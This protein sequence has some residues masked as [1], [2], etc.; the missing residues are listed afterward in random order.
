[1]HCVP[2]QSGTAHPLGA[3]DPGAW[4]P[5]AVDAACLHDFQPRFARRRGCG[6]GG[7]RSEISSLLFGC[8]GRHRTATASSR[9]RQS[10]PHLDCVN[11]S[12][13]SVSSCR[14]AAGST[15]SACFNALP[16]KKK[17]GYVTEARANLPTWYDASGL[18]KKRGATR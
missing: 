1:M 5:G 13:L 17:R 8:T 2:N 14:C 16:A 18:M 11:N 6:G 9:G 10:V 12:P 7:R 15:Q 4:Y 3:S